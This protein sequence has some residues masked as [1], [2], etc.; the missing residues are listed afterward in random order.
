[1]K[2]NF[3]QY[4]IYYLY[5]IIFFVTGKAVFLAYHQTK[6]ADLTAREIANVF[7]YGLYL[8]VSFT[9]YICIIPFF[10]FFL[11]TIIK[12]FKVGKIITL[13]TILLT[14][15]LSFSITADL[16]L[17]KAWGFKLD[18]AAL[19]YFNTPNEMAAS[20]SSS[21]VVVLMLI[22]I[23][24]S[25]FFILL[26]TI[27]IKRY[28]S[29]PV[30]R[31]NFIRI[32]LSFLLFVFLFVPIR[33]GFQ[34]IP[35]NQSNVYFSDK[36]FA[37]HAAINVPWNLMHSLL[38]KNAKQNP[39][40]YLTE[41]EARRYID[42]LYTQGKTSY[43]KVLTTQRP[44]IIFIILES[45]T[46]KLI[47]CLG[48]EPGITPHIDK[49]AKEGMLFTNIYASGERSEK[50]L[51]ALLSG[52]PTQTTTSIVMMPSKTE[53]L[54]HLNKILEKEG[55]H[56]SY[57]YGG[58]LA[59]ANIKSYLLNAGYDRLISKYDFRKDDY[60]S[61]WG[62]HDHVLLNRF[63]ND[64]KIGKQP[65]FSTLFTL[66]SHEPYDI[67][68]KPKLKGN[69]ETTKFKNSFSYT[70]EA[71]GNFIDQ[72]K[73]QWWWHNT[74]IVMVAD[75]GHVLPG[76]DPNDRPS[77]FKI[78]LILTGGALHSKG[79]TNHTV[80][81][82]TDIA[83]TILQQMGLSTNGFKWSK[84]LLDSNAKQFAF[85][86]FNNGFGFITDNGAVTFD[87]VSKKIIY[88]NKGADSQQLNIGKAYMQ[89]S[90]QD[91]LNRR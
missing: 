75:H 35:I 50:G 11:Q 51:V 21:P 90:F 40:N 33:G 54:P 37:N 70:D 87:N 28:I 9:A 84:N 45:Y 23:L 10:L 91:F 13:Y 83:F 65:F 73:T 16:E 25:T 34:Q 7:L 6:S 14:L 63:I 20:V 80:G 72:A 52:Y 56:S 62:V 24:F 2:F 48:G 66:S 36:L 38:K 41:S 44:N 5:W 27:F 67:P 47:G 8:D 79:H 57:Y 76:Y 1:V 30:S 18:A 81:S 85:Y 3:L 71:I 74:L 32:V 69:D 46:A 4:I 64:L 77:K 78:P 89:L 29:L 88:K 19:Q 58:E 86:V 59:F 43:P 82:Q 17:Y 68:A 61:K 53:K 60:N 55:Y 22:F 26:Y 42:L 39:Y 12:H 31:L 15:L 49:I